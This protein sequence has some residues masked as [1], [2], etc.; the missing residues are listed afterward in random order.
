MPKSRW[1]G[2]KIRR[3]NQAQ[4]TNIPDQA[5]VHGDYKHRVR[6]SGGA[7]WQEPH[8]KLIKVDMDGVK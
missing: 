6:G 3:M 8:E 1:E 5:C 4:Y 2:G 7:G